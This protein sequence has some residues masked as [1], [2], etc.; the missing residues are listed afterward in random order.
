M[1]DL[2]VDLKK[3]DATDNTGPESATES[4]KPRL[5]F[6]CS[7][8]RL[9]RL[10]CIAAA[11]KGFRHTFEN[12]PR[13]LGFALRPYRAYKELCK[14]LDAKEHDVTYQQIEDAA[15][16]AAD[17]ATERSERLDERENELSGKIEDYDQQIIDLNRQL[18]EANNTAL[19]TAAIVTKLQQQTA[20]LMRENAKLAVKLYQWNKIEKE[21]AAHIQ[22]A[23]DDIQ[24]FL[25]MVKT[26]PGKW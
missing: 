7:P 6:R 5:E 15:R 13:R 8:E 16:A 3:P 21:G 10:E 17:A 12:D 20:S 4:P 23:F 2:I 1:D 11:A 26:S 9:R 24:K 19:N 25:D 14:A 22:A 18:D